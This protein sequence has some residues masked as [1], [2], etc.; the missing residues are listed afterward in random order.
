MVPLARFYLVFFSVYSFYGNRRNI[1]LDSLSFF[2]NMQLFH[3]ERASDFIVNPILFHSSATV[4][5][6]CSYF[7]Q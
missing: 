4:Q 2:F 5:H 7:M 1:D 3:T 6:M